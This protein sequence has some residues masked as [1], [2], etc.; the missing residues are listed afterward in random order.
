MLPPDSTI[1]AL[2]RLLSDPNEQVARTIQDQLA[3]L[4][5]DVLPFLEQAGTEDTQLQPRI[6][7]IKGEI[8]FG[9][10]REEFKKFVTQSARQED[11]EQGAFLIAKLA[12]PDIS[13]PHYVERLDELAEEFRKKWHATDSPF[14]K[15]ARLLS[16]FLFKDK[17]FSGNRESY[18]DPD[19]SY[20]NRVLDT[21]QGIPISLSAIY[22]FV[23]TRLGLPVAGVGMPGHFLIKLEGESSPQF[24]DCFN[25]GTILREEDCKRFITASGLEYDPSLLEKSATP[26]ILAR[27]LR[28]LLSIY[29]KQSEEHM[30]RRVRAFLEL[31]END[32]IQ[33]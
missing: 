10:V 24:I 12:Y 17:G 22:F 27:M 33:P 28:N 31:L 4:G 19:N 21:R 32:Q 23:G 2:L 6:T 3:H 5:P 15:A 30:A 7:F 8:R 25:G 14:G 20:L 26:T 11:W 18:Y 13:I 16:T 1:H 9:Q 29:E